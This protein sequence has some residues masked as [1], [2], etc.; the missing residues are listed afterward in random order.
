M[1]KFNNGRGAVICD[2][3]R[4]MIDRDIS[5]EEYEEIY[6]KTG[7]KGDFCH[8]CINNTKNEKRH[9]NINKPT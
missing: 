2:N 1:Y 4:I 7:N 5:L 3:C 8:N 6:S 9:E